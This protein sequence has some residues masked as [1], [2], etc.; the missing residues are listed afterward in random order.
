MATDP[1]AQPAPKK[2]NDD[3]DSHYCG[4]ACTH[5]MGRDDNGDPILCGAK[6][7]KMVTPGDGHQTYGTHRCAQH[8]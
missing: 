8:R 3:A 1:N 2:G 6:C 4:Y 5:E 7:C